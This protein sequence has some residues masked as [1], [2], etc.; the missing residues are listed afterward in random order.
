MT[1][2]KGGAV[3]EDMMADGVSGELARQAPTTSAFAKVC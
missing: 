3:R 1:G 2:V